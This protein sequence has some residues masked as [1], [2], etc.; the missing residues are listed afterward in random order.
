MRKWGKCW[1]ATVLFGIVKE[2]FPGERRVASVPGVVP[3][4]VKAGWQ[5]PVEGGAGAEAGYP[6]TLCHPNSGLCSS[7]TLVPLSC[8]TAPR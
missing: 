2:T 6:D 7:G 1:I 3:T 8:P 4:L 5:A